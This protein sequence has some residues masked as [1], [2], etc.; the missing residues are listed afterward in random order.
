[1]SSRIGSA[2]QSPNPLCGR[3]T[4]DPMDSWPVRYQHNSQ[5]GTLLAQVWVN[6]ETRALEQRLAALHGAPPATVRSGARRLPHSDCGGDR[7]SQPRLAPSTLKAGARHT[8][9]PP[10]PAARRCPPA[11]EPPGPRRIPRAAGIAIALGRASRS[12]AARLRGTSTVRR[13]RLSV[14]ARELST[15][16]QSAVTPSTRQIRRRVTT[17]GRSARRARSSTG[18]RP[19]SARASAG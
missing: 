12:S 10:S 1:M 2:R 9:N 4:Y 7:D 11:P 19:R 15:A 13:P 8:K 3:R 6:Q 18:A 5:W 16:V 17:P 14:S